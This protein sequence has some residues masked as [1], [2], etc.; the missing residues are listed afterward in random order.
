MRGR[1]VQSLAMIRVV[2]GISGIE[3]E[4]GGQENHL[5]LVIF[6]SSIFLFA[7]FWKLD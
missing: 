2:S 3:Q 4:N 5:R 1:R 7:S 6:L